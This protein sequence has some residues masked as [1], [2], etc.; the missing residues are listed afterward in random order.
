MTTREYLDS[1]E[2]TQPRELTYG[3]L[4]EPAAPFFSHQEVVLK[5]ARVLADHVERAALGRIAVAPIDVVLDADRA[6]ILQ[7]DV[8]FVSNERAAI[9]RDQVWGAPDLVVEVLSVP[10][11]GR[12]RTEKLGWYRQYGVRECWLVDPVAERVIIVDFGGAMPERRSM[13]RDEA[14]RSSVLPAFSPTLASLLP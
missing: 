2:T 4:R 9:V 1:Y 3:I 13:G 7:P 11:A 8:L 10:T 12:D 6:L 5:I 14:I